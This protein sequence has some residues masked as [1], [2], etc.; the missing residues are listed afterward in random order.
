MAENNMNYGL[1]SSDI[2]ALAGLSGIGRGGYGGYGGYGGGGHGASSNPAIHARVDELGRTLASMGTTSEN[3]QN[4]EDVTRQATATSERLT[5]EHSDIRSELSAIGR[6]LANC[7]CEQK[8]L[9][10]DSVIAINA[11]TANLTAQLCDLDRSFSS[12]I[13]DLQIE[14]KNDTISDLKQTA[15]S[16]QFQNGFNALAAQL[17]AL[18]QVIANGN[19][20]GKH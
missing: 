12:Q 3:R 8:L 2:A 10:K 13:T 4:L 7:C 14:N 17:A 5:A 9:A 16:N 1:G 11:Q 20:N 15:Q 6:D 19:G 18:T